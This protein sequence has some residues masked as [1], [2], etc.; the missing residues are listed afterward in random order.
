MHKVFISYHHQD[1]GFKDALLDLN[2]KYPM[3]LDWSVDT[4]D[5]SDSLSDQAIRMK[6]RDEYLRDSSVTLLLVG[7]GTKGRK[8]VD[9][10]VYSSMIDGSINR[11]SGLLAVLLPAANPTSCWHA[12]HQNEKATVYPQDTRWYNIESRQQYEEQYPYLPDRIIDNLLC[13]DVA[14]SV[15]PW[16]KLTTNTIP[17]LVENAFNAR[18]SNRYDLRRPMRRANRV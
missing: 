9:W 11:R 12:A 18:L 16:D 17:L 8:H 3:F 14:L 2:E 15:V 5:I 6:I 4:G 13:P 10:E 7:L 1:Q